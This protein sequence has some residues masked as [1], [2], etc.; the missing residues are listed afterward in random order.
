M[1]VNRIIRHFQE[2]KLDTTTKD[3][4]ICVKVYLFVFILRDPI[5][6]YMQLYDYSCNYMINTSI[7][8]GSISLLV[9]ILTFSFFFITS[10]SQENQANN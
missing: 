5:K 9:T 6:L 7:Y 8:R 1:G 2:Y 10:S 3:G 4:S